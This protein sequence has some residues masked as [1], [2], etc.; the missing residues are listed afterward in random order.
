[1]LGATLAL[2]LALAGVVIYR[3][4]YSHAF[5]KALALLEEANAKDRQAM[6]ALGIFAD[7]RESEN[8]ALAILNFFKQSVEQA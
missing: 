4:G 8:Q 3:L 1:M 5:S 7:R 2:A 6:E